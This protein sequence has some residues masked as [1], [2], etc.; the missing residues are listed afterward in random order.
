LLTNKHHT[1][2]TKTENNVEFTTDTFETNKHGLIISMI[3]QNLIEFEAQNLL[4][5][6][7]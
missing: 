3:Y 4:Q 1:K 7:D 6:K 2:V 5:H